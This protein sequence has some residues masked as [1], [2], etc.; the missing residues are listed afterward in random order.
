MFVNLLSKEGANERNG[1]LLS[2]KSI[3][4]N[5]S[6]ISDVFSY[7]VKVGVVSDNPCSKVM[8]VEISA[9]YNGLA[10]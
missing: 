10:R 3:K 2:P 1:K 8:D 5:L 6:L 7:A 4:H 9:G